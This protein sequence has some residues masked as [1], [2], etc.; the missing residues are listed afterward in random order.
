MG[1]TN[2]DD[3]STPEISS[4][5]KGVT[6][7]GTLHTEGVERGFSPTETKELLRKIDWALLPLLSLLYLLSFLDRANIGNAR[8]AGLEEDLGMTGKWDYSVSLRSQAAT[9][10]S[11]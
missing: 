1:A 11:F 4:A 3:S 2:G 7:P 10:T 8:L 5:E 9:Y 6:Q